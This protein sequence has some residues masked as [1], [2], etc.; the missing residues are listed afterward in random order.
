MIEPP[1]V[2]EPSLAVLHSAFDALIESA[3]K[4][5]L[6]QDEINV[7]TLHRVNSFIPSWPYKKPLLSKLLDRTYRKYKGV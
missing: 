6:D 3:R 5:A 1:T 2:N 7:F 4:I